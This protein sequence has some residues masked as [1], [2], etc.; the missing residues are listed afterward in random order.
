VPAKR[1][2]GSSYGCETVAAAKVRKSPSHDNDLG[3]AVRP[4]YAL[5]R[6]EDVYQPH[7]VAV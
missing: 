2:G 6:E 7:D 1:C 5:A 4:V 3:H